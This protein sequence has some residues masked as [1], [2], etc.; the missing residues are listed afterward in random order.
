[1]TKM[2]QDNDVTDYTGTFCIKNKTKLPWSIKQGAIYEKKTWYDNNVTDRTTTVFF[3]NEI[4]LSWAIKLD[5]IYDKND[6]KQWCYQSYRVQ[7]M[8]TITQDND[9]TYHIGATEIELSW[10]MG[11]SAIYDENDKRQRRHRSYRCG[12]YRKWNW[13]VMTNG[14][15]CNLWQK[16][17][18]TTT[19]PIV[20]MWSMPKMK[21]NCCDWLGKE[22]SKTKTTQDKDMINRTCAVSAENETELLWLIG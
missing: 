16:W 19:S 15:G 11:Q 9:G 8:M 14:V 13:T 2:T 20:H 21:L 17:H 18:R 10:S 7:S 6:T 4:E 22:R 3:K 5:A 1:M 12:L